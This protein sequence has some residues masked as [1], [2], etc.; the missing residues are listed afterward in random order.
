MCVVLVIISTIWCVSMCAYVVVII[1]IHCCYLV[2]MCYRLWLPQPLACA[3]LSR[4]L[5]FHH[6]RFAAVVITA[7]TVCVC[8]V[9]VIATLG[10]LL[11]LSC[12]CV[13]HINAA[14]SVYVVIVVAQH[15]E[16]YTHTDT[17]RHTH[18]PQ[19]SGDD[20]YDD[21][22][23]YNRQ[24]SG[25]GGGGDTVRTCRGAA[26]AM[27][28][29]YTA[30]VTTLG[31]SVCVVCSC[32]HHRHSHLAYMRVMVLCVCVVPAVTLYTC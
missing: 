5:R 23:T 11:S 1:L 18:I 27:R 16:T 25:D 19:G 7:L 10:V 20:N 21:N 30:V 31:P 13:I 28:T 4:R 29:V 22:S 12:V 17:Q 2:C 32:Y 14:T 15:T 24:I 9:L 26:S 8:V 6:Y 3:L